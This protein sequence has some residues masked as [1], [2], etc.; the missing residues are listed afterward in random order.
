MLDG[1]DFLSQSLADDDEADAEV[2]VPDSNGKGEMGNPYREFLQEV[3]ALL[4]ECTAMPILRGEVVPP[5][6]HAFLDA[7]FGE[8]EIVPAPRGRVGAMQSDM[9]ELLLKVGLCVSCTWDPMTAR[10]AA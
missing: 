5:E 3:A 1:I 2:G 9:E 4:S 8:V 10:S 7:K 6:L